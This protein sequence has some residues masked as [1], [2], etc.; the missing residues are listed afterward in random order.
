MKRSVLM[1]NDLPK[2]IRRLYDDFCIIKDRGEMYGCPENFNLMTVAWYLNHSKNPNVG[3]DKDYIFSALKDIK[4]GEELT[5]DYN[6]YNEF[7][8]PNW[9]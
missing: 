1:L 3:C 8:D 6:T 4:K 7:A 5:A 9:V 2:E